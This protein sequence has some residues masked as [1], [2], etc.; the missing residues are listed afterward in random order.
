MASVRFVKKSE[1]S[2]IY[3]RATQG[4]TI[5]QTISTNLDIPFKDWD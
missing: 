3:L 5:E 2:C 4:K 1:K